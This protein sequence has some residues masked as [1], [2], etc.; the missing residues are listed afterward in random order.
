MSYLFSVTSFQNCNVLVMGMIRIMYARHSVSTS[1]YVGRSIMHCLF[2]VTSFHNHYLLTLYS[3]VIALWNRLARDGVS[4]RPTVQYD[5]IFLRWRVDPHDGGHNGIMEDPEEWYRQRR[6]G[7]KVLGNKRSTCAN[8]LTCN[9]P[10][11]PKIDITS[12]P[13]HDL[14]G[15]GLQKRNNLW[16]VEHFADR[17]MRWGVLGCSCRAG[18]PP[19]PH[20]T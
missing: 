6:S 11:K 12:L 19:P 14:F 1:I 8:I 20:I 7:I 10:R 18:C 16:S 17:W 4:P 9:K 13:T 5:I 3:I 2:L 15:A